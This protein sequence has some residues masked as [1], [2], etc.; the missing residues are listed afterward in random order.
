M[1]CVPCDMLFA[2]MSLNC[3]ASPTWVGDGSRLPGGIA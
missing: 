3:E 1:D 2:R